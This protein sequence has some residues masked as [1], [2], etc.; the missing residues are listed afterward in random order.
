MDPP[1]SHRLPLPKIID[2]PMVWDVRDPVIDLHQFSFTREAPI[3]LV[4]LRMNK[5]L[6]RS[7]VGDLPDEL[8][9]L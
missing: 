7:Y 2:I 6:T 5:G 9:S 8:D 1:P 3:A 4:L